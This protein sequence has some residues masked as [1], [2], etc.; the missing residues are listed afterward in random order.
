MPTANG[1]NRREFLRLGLLGATAMMPASAANG[2]ELTA[3]VVE[4]EGALIP[5]EFT[6]VQ[7]TMTNRSATAAM[8]YSMK[9][10]QNDPV[11]W[12]SS[13]QGEHIGDYGPEIRT[14]RSYGD[15]HG[16]SPLPPKQVKLEPGKEETW[17]G[18]LC[19]YCDAL[20]P[21]KY[22]LKAEHQLKEGDEMTQSSPAS[23]EVVAA[24]VG[25]WAMSYTNA[26]RESTTLVWAGTPL[27]ARGPGRVLVRDSGI[28]RHAFLRAGASP[29]PGLAASARLSAGQSP[30]DAQQ[31]V[32]HWVG[33]AGVKGVEMVQHNSTEPFWRSKPVPFGLINIMPIPRFPDRGHAVYLATGAGVHGPELVGCKVDPRLESDP[34]PW[35]VVLHH[36]PLLT[37]AS[38]GMQGPIHILM[39]STDG[40]SHLLS[41]LAVDETGKVVSEEAVVRTGSAKVLAIAVDMRPGAI[42]KFLVLEEDAKEHGRVTLVHIPVAGRIDAAPPAPLPGWPA[43]LEGQKYIALPAREVTLEVAGDGE[44]FVALTDENDN[45]YGGSVLDFELKLLRPGKKPNG[46]KQSAIHPHIGALKGGTTISCFTETGELFHFVASQHHSH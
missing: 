19:R 12:V 27:H 38:F 46:E 33:A 13:S 15:Q 22:Q 2:V 41:R 43:K 8:V 23:F 25:D 21:G 6:M 1:G 10:A 11:L 34:A 28:T 14:F 16:V 32:L 30:V 18:N 31:L 20:P 26:E 3:R 4:P 42:P 29:I 37:G 7:V 39:A 24:E 45:F 44:P 35:R 17:L 36:A 9:S 40:A 5:E